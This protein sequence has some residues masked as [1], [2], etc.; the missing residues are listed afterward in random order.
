[1]APDVLKS[2]APWSA[3]L[4]LNYF[5]D[6][7][8]GDNE[9]LRKVVMEQKEVLLIAVKYSPNHHFGPALTLEGKRSREAYRIEIMIP[10]H[11]VRAIITDE[12]GRMPDVGFAS[13][14]RKTAKPKG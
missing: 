14:P 6:S 7:A 8:K 12:T 9:G 1:M 3:L 13:R 10:W 4:F 11:S 5:S 2:D